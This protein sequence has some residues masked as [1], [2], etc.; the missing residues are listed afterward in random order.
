M[1]ASVSAMIPQF[2]KAI[3]LGIQSVRS[4]E[5]RQQ[6]L[7]RIKKRISCFEGVDYKPEGATAV[8]I[9]KEGKKAA[10]DAI[11]Y[12]KSS[13][14]ISSL[15][16]DINPSIPLSFSSEDHAFDVGTAGVASH[17]G[18]DSSH[19]RDRIERYC[20][21][22]KKCSEIIWYGKI[23]DEKSLQQTAFDIID[24]LIIDDG[25]PDRGHRHA[26]FDP[27][28]RVGGVG[29][30][31]HSVYSNVVVV[32]MAYDVV[33]ESNFP[34]YRDEEALTHHV[35]EAKQKVVELFT[36]L[37]LTK[38]QLCQE[39]A[40][41]GPIQLEASIQRAAKTELET[42][43]QLIGECYSCKKGIKGGRVVEINCS[44]GQNSM[45]FHPECFNC[46]YCNIQLQGK[47]IEQITNEK[48][49]KSSV[50]CKECWDMKHAPICV[51]CE[52]RI[53]ENKY[54]IVNGGKLHTCCVTEYKEKLNRQLQKGGKEKE[55]QTNTEPG[56]V[57]AKKTMNSLMSEYANL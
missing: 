28:L 37:Y 4:D 12:L 55:K 26:I 40:V 22:R 24:D 7:Q 13:H 8:R 14:D 11:S 50:I 54:S 32:N 1:G 57:G 16:F 39:R 18:S 52:K 42:Q 45:K 35:E 17:Q 25:V 51:G 10:E 44:N 56:M 34:Y 53:T 21:W 15:V 47:R 31:S 6:C 20:I 5:G 9:T 2:E 30:A 29:F 48:G 38:S 19:S 3:L 43:W 23:T 46:N 27:M 33:N 41:S 49:E 36:Q